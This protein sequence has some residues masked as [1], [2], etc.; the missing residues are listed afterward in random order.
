MA[1]AF[2]CRIGH[3]L[4]ILVAVFVGAGFCSAEEQPVFALQARGGFSCVVD[5]ISRTRLPVRFNDDLDNGRRYKARRFWNCRE[6]CPDGGCDHR[7]HEPVWD[8]LYVGGKVDGEDDLAEVQ[9]IASAAARRDAQV[10]LEVAE[11]GDVVRLWPD[12]KKGGK[13]EILAG[14]AL[15]FSAADLPKSVFVEGIRPGGAILRLVSVSE[16]EVEAQLHVDVL[17]M[18]IVQ[19]GRRKAIYDAGEI[20]LQ[21]VPEDILRLPDYRRRIEWSGDAGGSRQ[22]EVVTYDP[23]SSAVNRRAVFRPAVT[24]NGV[25]AF[26][27]SV[28]VRQKTF[29][30]TP[31]AKTTAE[32]RREVEK[33]VPIPP[34]SFKNTELPN[35]PSVR[36]SQAWFEQRYT[37][38]ATAADPVKPINQSRLQY[39]PLLVKPNDT[40]WGRACCYLSPYGIFITKNAYDDLQLEDLV[41]VAQ[42]ELR[43]LEHHSSMY[44][45]TGF[46]HVLCR[47]LSHDVATYFMEADA[48]S[49]SLHSDGS[50]RYLHH[51]ARRTVENYR[52]AGEEVANLRSLQEIESAITVLQDIYKGLPADMDEFTRPGYDC[53]IRPPLEMGERDLRAR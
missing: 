45:A 46:W 28:R 32:R 11:G 38:S 18:Q 42:H 52:K 8:Y 16:S 35:K 7:T 51:C 41:A 47:D 43:H 3:C 5:G 22:R 12:A 21:L 23:G 15:L 14:E 34:L 50:W 1:R 48:S 6:M 26:A 19:N 10:R 37:G 2:F 13:G 4:Q 24:V 9:L 39:A 53:Y 17:A 27:K 33:M 31:A 25:L 40:A 20:S 36:F 29:T 49:A 44:A 30:G